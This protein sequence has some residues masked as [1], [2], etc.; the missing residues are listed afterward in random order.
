MSDMQGN[1]VRRRTGGGPPSA[2]AAAGPPETHYNPR[3]HPGAKAVIE[4]HLQA[5]KQGQGQRLRFHYG[6]NETG[7]AWGDTESGYVGRSTGSQKIPLVVH[8]ARSMG[9]GGLLDANVV[10]IESTRKSKGAHPVLWQH[11]NYHEGG[12]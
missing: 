2:L 8:N 7:R 6:D 11:P 10:K 4:S 3:T 12:E 5:R 1:A 9:G